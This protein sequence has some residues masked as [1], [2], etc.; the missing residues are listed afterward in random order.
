MAGRRY[1]TTI[2]GQTF[3]VRV[4]AREADSVLVSVGDGTPEVVRL[5]AEGPTL[6]V[7]IGDRVVELAPSGDGSFAA[8]GGVGIA[9]ATRRDAAR[10]SAATASSGTVQA[11]MPGRIVKLLVGAGDQVAAG[12]GLVVMEAMKM[13]N[14]IAAPHAGTVARVLVSAGDTV[15]RDAAL[16]ELAAP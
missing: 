12:A 8:R 11:P 4:E 13:E 3:A 9:I 1:T 5:I 16:V 6:T 15:D 14:E 10:A 7:L 2:D